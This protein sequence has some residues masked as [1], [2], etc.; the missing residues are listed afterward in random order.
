MSST[1]IIAVD[2]GASSGRVTQANF[3]GSSLHLE[4]VHRFRNNPVWAGG[5][6]YWDVLGLWRE[7]QE[8]IKHVAPGAQSLG[9]DT[10]GV[11]FVLLDRSG[12]LVSNP[13]HYR[14]P[15]SIGMMEWV[16]ERMPKREIY[17]RTG[18]QFIEL[19]SLYQLAGM[20]KHNIAALDHAAHFM[21]L[22]DLFPYWMTGEL[23]SEYTAVSTSQ[24]YNLHSRDWDHELMQAV[25]IPTD[26][27]T[28]IVPAGSIV[29]DYEGIQ[30]IKPGSH[31]TASA[32]VAVPSNSRNMAYISSGT[33]SLL[34][35]E[36]DAPVNSDAAFAANA[37]NEGGV[38]DTI[39]FLRNIAGMWIIEQLRS[40]WHDEGID[41]DFGTMVEM[42]QAAPAFKAY[43]D[44]DDPIFHLPGDMENKIR[45]FCT[46]THQPAPETHG[47]CIRI[48][49]EGL[50]MKYRYILRLLM[51][52]AG[53]EVDTLHII[54]GGS[55]NELLN[56]MT[57]NAVGIQVMSG[58]D[59]ATATGNALIQLITLG[60]L[61]SLSEARELVRRYAETK[62][63]EPKNVALWD[64][65]FDHFKEY[66]TVF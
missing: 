49:Y 42:A 39:R 35:L 15:R 61:G 8:G 47:E 53:K 33:W 26:I 48:A 12:E 30:V 66:M 23:S 59:E 25:G 60:H 4:A 32:V 57:A 3:D 2:L 11:D 29:G 7:V 46:R 14:N 65:H 21:M 52:A 44:P 18:L 5:N 19:N 62:I 56:Q 51:S 6:L 58:P 41:Y 54:G 50:A 36:L 13:L 28:K 37:T 27:F 63:F 43:I 1:H 20:I 9:F 22:P 45:E 24:L 64:E 31:D 16:Y 34:G 10:W 55:R 17:D 40:T 38:F